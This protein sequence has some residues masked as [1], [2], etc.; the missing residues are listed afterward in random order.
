[1]LYRGRSGDDHSPVLVLSSVGQHPSQES[2]NRLANEYSLKDELDLSWAA[3]PIGFATHS[4][5]TVL[6]LQDPGGIPLESVSGSRFYGRSA[7]AGAHGREDNRLDLAFWLRAAINLAAAI[8]ALHRQGIIHKNIKPANVLVDPAGGHCWL[9]GFG[10]ASRLPRERQLPGPPEFIAGTLAYMAPEQTGRMNRSIDSRSDLYALGVTLYEMLTGTL[11]FAASDPMEW[12]HCHIARQPLSP[13]QRSQAVP[14]LVSAIVMKLLAKTA[15]ERYQT[16]AGLQTD[17]QRCLD[18]CESRQA[19]TRPTRL[20]SP[21]SYRIKEFPL[22]QH[23]TPDRLRIPEKLYG[24]A[25][26]IDTLLASFDR[27]VANGGPELVL[28]SGYSGIGKSSVVNELHKVLVPPRGLFASGKFDQ[29]KRNAPYSTLAQ[30]FQ[31]LVRPLLAKS[32][33]E[34]C[35]WRDALREAL[36]PNGQLMVDLVPEL[37]LI[38]GAQPTVPD[39]PP[40]DAKAR[41]QRVFLRFVG[42]FARAEHPLALFLDDLQW[43][44]AATLDFLQELLISDSANQQNAGPVG[45]KPPRQASARPT[46]EDLDD[47]SMR[48]QGSLGEVGLGRTGQPDLR[49]LILIGAY[50]DNEVDSAHPLR[51]KLDAIRQ[52]GAHIQEIVLSPLACD[53]LARLLTDTLHCE[54]GRVMPLARL[55]HDKTAGNP[56]FAIQFISTLIDEAFLTF[57][58]SVGRWSWDVGRIQGKGYTDNVVDLM[59]RK[60]NRLSPETQTALE[61]FACLGNSTTISELSFV[62]GLVLNSGASS[63]LQAPAPPP[64]QGRAMAKR[65]QDG[66]GGPVL[67]NLGDGGTADQKITSILWE[68][69]RLEFIVRSEGSYKFVHDR[70]HEAAYSLIP[71]ELR[72]SAHLRI[73]RLLLARTPPEKREEE[74]FEIVGQLNRG[75]ALITSRDERQEVAALNLLAG[76]RAKTSAAYLSALNYLISG[77]ALLADDAWEGNHGLAFALELNRAECEFLTGQLAAAE[78]RLAA[79]SMRAAGTV[80]QATVTCLRVDL[81][82]TLDRSSSAIAVGLDYLRNMGINWSP[83]PTDAEARSEYERVWS[84]LGSRAIEDLV[85]IP[86]MSDPAWLATMDVLVKMWPPSIMTDVN[87]QTLVICRAVNLSLEHGNSDGS[88]AAY[89]WLGGVVAGGRFND[90]K[91]GFRFGRVGYELTERGSLRRFQA[92][93]YVNFSDVVLP[94]TKPFHASQD[95]LRRAFEAA[96]KSG[97]LTYGLYSRSHLDTHLLAGGASL[98]EVQR[99]AELGFALARKAQFGHV[100]DSI[101]PQLGLIRTLRGLTRKFGVFDDDQFQESQIEDHFSNNPELPLAECWYWIRKLQARFYA[102]DYAAALNASSRIE[103]LIKVAPGWLERAEYEFYASLLHAVAW[104]SAPANECQQH[105]ESLARHHQ[106]LKI[107]AENCPENFKDRHALVSA[108]IARI[109]GREREAARL[110]EQ[111]IRSAHTSGFVHNEALANELAGRFY[112]ALGFE[113]IAQVYLRDARYCYLR[114]GANGKIKQLDELYPYLREEDRAR[115]SPGRQEATSGITGTI[116]ASVEQLDLGTVI[117]VSQAVSGEILLE[118]L[119]DTLMRTAIEHAGAERGLLILTRGDENRIECEATTRGDTVIVSVREGPVTGTTLPASIVRYVTRTKES[120]ILDDAS[121]QNRFSEDEYLRQRQSKSVLC[122]PLVKQTR[123]MGVL[124]L[125]NN[126]APR[127]FTSGRLALLELL[128][129]QAAISLDNARLYAD[130]AELNVELTQENS[131]RRRA[132]EALRAS[133]QRL[134]D[135][136]DNTSAVIFVKDLELRFVLVNREFERRHGVRRD[137][138]RGKTDFD[139]HP[140]EVAEAVRTNDAQ[141][142]E[143]GAPIQFV[144]VVPSEQGNRCYICVKFLLHDRNKEPY[145]VCGIA[146]D[147]TERKQ[148]EEAL[149]QAQVEL[150]RVSQM[151]TMEQ[152]AAS[153]AHEVNQPLAA[154]VTSGDACLNWLSADPPNLRKARDAVERMV[155][156]GNRAS[157][158]LKRVRTLLRKTPHVKSSVNVNEV[159]Q[160]VLALASGELR[161]HSV[162]W[163]TELEVSLPSVTADFVQLQ[164]VLLNLVMNAI[165]SMATTA[166]R[167]R[168]LRIQSQ[169][170]ASVGRSAVL[171]A[172]HDSGA[173]LTATEMVQV[174]EAFYSTK[175]E[176]MGMG[177]WI[178]RSIIEAHGGQLTARANDAGGATF[179]FVLPPSTEQGA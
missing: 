109:E 35:R 135:I 27:V 3:R 65:R 37:K 150:A 93:V 90:Y 120:V 107:W 121:V 167:P 104:G 81:Y 161:K 22:G 96:N 43:L 30:A 162:E 122:L 143:A 28:V 136:I 33:A 7:T 95:L 84:Q 82:M 164:Q 137:Q 173:G 102:G 21:K 13:D 44:D 131:D 158:V 72:A 172:V 46:A 49:S 152:L 113:K 157:D 140:N 19:G 6:V 125:E 57:D 38:I 70:V 39:L 59:V 176:G 32:E 76:K 179:Q 18:Q 111:A 60:L 174:F 165:E 75:A 42:V 163:S 177:L 47:P 1:M 103:Q 89:T 36:D 159:I 134:Q 149:H 92:R 87:L 69:E 78:E 105:F 51:R 56:F 98:D 5:R 53:D 129:S 86:L 85:D 100:M 23:D 25:H 40:Q 127:V 48:S 61:E 20:S 52:A 106:Q 83:H 160:E 101:S 126:L 123:L 11:P 12:V 156:D 17:L 55:V 16:A 166:N 153:I 114:W 79:L 97:D 77:A 141:V 110:Y 178:C 144:E 58:H 24:R 14:A 168:E 9:T 138:I 115:L 99:E 146:T 132:E 91:A 68:A 54:P 80:E 128:T 118:K 142:V 67:Q 8:G 169:V 88:C 74:I 170:D 73:G 117:K 116:G 124:Y 112:A 71:E 62:H 175:P 45:A 119:I 154:V 171:V 145:A 155:Q 10:I 15:E 31:G 148:A 151:T 66:T 29:Y 41:F 108:E 63:A 64:K 4:D 147:I 2:I 94:W 26:E 139:I 50:R 130:L 34:L 133:E